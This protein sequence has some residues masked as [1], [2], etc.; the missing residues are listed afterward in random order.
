MHASAQPGSRKQL[1]R[2]CSGPPLHGRLPRPDEALPA[3]DGLPGPSYG[4]KNGA[5]R[6]RPRRRFQHTQAQLPLLPHRPGAPHPILRRMAVHLKTGIQALPLRC[7]FPGRSAIPQDRK[8]VHRFSPSPQNNCPP[9]QPYAQAGQL[10]S[11]FLTRWY[12]FP[13]PG[14]W[15]WLRWPS[16]PGLQWSSCR[17]DSAPTRLRDSRFRRWSRRSVPVWKAKHR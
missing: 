8:P 4:R 17:D 3:T 6:Q 14:A 9:V 13:G 5:A 1:L 10:D 15:W 2:L 12:R 11:I 16:R 7:Q